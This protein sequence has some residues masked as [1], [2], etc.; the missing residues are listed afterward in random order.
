MPPLPPNAPRRHGRFSRRAARFLLR[1]LGWQV[2][3]D[4]PNVAKCVVIGA[5]HTSNFDGLYAL[6]ALLA[7]DLKV[8]ILGKQSL[9]AVPGVAALMRWLGVVP[10]DR[11]NAGGVVEASIDTFR[12]HGQLFLGI[13]PEGTRRA[14]TQWKSGYWRIA[15]GA[16][17]PILPAVLDYGR[18][19]IRFLPLFHPGEDF[20]ADQAALIA[21]YRGVPPKHPG[22][23]SLPL[24][25]G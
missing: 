6:P 20:A 16:G 14:A 3:G 13:A 21:L 9:F 7:M 11:S 17:V 23:L 25:G 12:R 18:K 1:L 10:L 22:R 19:E 2:K 24:R 15:R 8:S 5:P 4:I